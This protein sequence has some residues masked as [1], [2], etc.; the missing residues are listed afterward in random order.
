MDTRQFI[1]EHL[2][3]DVHELALK[4]RN[5]KVDMA[6]ALRQIAARQLLLKKVPSWSGNEDLLFP[7]HLSLEQCSSEAAALYKASLLQGDTFADLTGGLGVDCY[8][9]SRRFERSDYVE[10]NPELCN[11]AEHNFA[12][13]AAPDLSVFNESAEDYLDHC[14]PKDCLFLD[15]S[16]RDAQGHKTVSIADCTPDVTALQE[17]LLRLAPRVMVKLSP[18]LDL[19]LALRQLRQVAQVHVVAVANEC[20]ELLFLLEAGYQGEPVFTC[21]NLLTDQPAVH[22]TREEESAC[23]PVLAD[24]VLSYLYE[25]HAALLKAGCFKLL[26]QRFGVRKLHRNS[27]LYTSDALVAGFPGRVFKV[28]GWAPYNKAIRQTLLQGVGQA[29]VAVRNFPLDVA[30]LRKALRISDGDAVYLFATQLT[31]DRKV[32]VKTVKAIAE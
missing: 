9:I 4:Y 11:L 12:T 25:P 13:L 24:E 30:T 23:Q 3:D 14:G 31:G 8:F 7:S 1:A 27:H 18:M 19:S 26:T 10:Q 32:I 5:A 21:V 20:K 16:R 15:P 17:R 22:F 6:L 28:E 29:S 2:H